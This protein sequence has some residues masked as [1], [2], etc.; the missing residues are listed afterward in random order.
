MMLFKLAKCKQD[1]SHR[2][3]MLNSFVTDI[4]TI[5]QMI[6]VTPNK[7]ESKFPTNRGGIG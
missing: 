7:I 2:F 1:Y 5:L 6:I 4:L 3:C